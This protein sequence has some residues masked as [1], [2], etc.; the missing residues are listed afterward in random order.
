M[1]KIE[2]PDDAGALWRWMVQFRVSIEEL[3]NRLGM[4]PNY[5]GEIRRGKKRPSDAL[6]LAIAR[7]T[8]AIEAELKVAKPRGVPVD[9]WY[10]AEAVADLGKR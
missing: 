5:L 8:L 9:A 10:T 1:P 3:S 6:K 7:E 4:A 2:L